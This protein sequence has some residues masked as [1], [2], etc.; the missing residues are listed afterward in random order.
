MITN[1]NWTELERE[2]MAGHHW[3]SEADLVGSNEEV[4]PED[5]A[6]ILIKAGVWNVA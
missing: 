1:V 5:L 4:W 6:D 3:W 2:V